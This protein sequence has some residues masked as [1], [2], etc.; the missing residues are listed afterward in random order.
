MTKA[1]TTTLTTIT[2]VWDLSFSSRLS[3]PSNLS[4]PVQNEL[5][6]S[7]YYSCWTRSLSIYI[8]LEARQTSRQSHNILYNAFVW[9]WTVPL[10]CTNPFSQ[11]HEILLLV[12]V[13]RFTWAIPIGRLL[14]YTT[15]SSITV[16][17]HAQI[18]INSD[19][20]LVST[21]SYLDRLLYW[22]IRT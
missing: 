18:N 19:K 1:T 3:F 11:L 7:T 6:C 22:T 16:H 20:C 5:K 15:M 4:N 9:C 17:D 21:S 10:T 13:A 14:H 12:V 2:V 8:G